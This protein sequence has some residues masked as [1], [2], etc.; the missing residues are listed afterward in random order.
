MPLYLL[1]TPIGSD[2]A[3]NACAASEMLCPVIP[4]SNVARIGI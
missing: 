1:K 3:W 2:D 4:E